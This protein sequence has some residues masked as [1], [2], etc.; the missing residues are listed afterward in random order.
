MDIQQPT[1]LDDEL[2]E[3][4]HSLRGSLTEL[5][6]S[7]GGD[8][9]KPQEVSRRFGIDKSLAWKV[10]RVIKAMA[11]HEALTHVPGVAAFEILFETM[12]RAGRR[13][14]R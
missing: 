5:I 6:A 11:P 7:A 13:C 4:V 3:S 9:R 1:I 12:E 2:N 8:A 10:S 14:P